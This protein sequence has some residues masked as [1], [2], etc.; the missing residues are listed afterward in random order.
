[1]LI[2]GA[3]TEMSST[4]LGTTLPS[5]AGFSWVNAQRKEATRLFRREYRRGKAEVLVN[6]DTEDVLAPLHRAELGR[7]LD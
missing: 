2:P 3:R 6:G 7:V 5:S 4:K 1:M